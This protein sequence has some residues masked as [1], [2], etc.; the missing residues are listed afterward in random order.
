MAGSMSSKPGPF[1]RLSAVE[2]SSLASSSVPE[3]S[4]S[5]TTGRP[6]RASRF[7]GWMSLWVSTTGPGRS[8]VSTKSGDRE[9]RLDVRRRARRPTAVRSPPPARRAR[10][11]PVAS[12]PRSSTWVH[13]TSRAWMR[14]RISPISNANAAGTGASGTFSPSTHRCTSTSGSAEIGSGI[15]MPAANAACSNR[16]TSSASVGPAAVDEV[17][18]LHR[19][20][21]LVGV[22]PVHPVGALAV[23]PSHRPQRGAQV[24]EVHRTRLRGIRP[25][26]STS[27][28]CCRDRYR[29]RCRHPCR[30]PCRR[31]PDPPPRLPPEPVEQPGRCPDPGLRDAA[32]DPVQRVLRAAHDSR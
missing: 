24:I 9:K 6:S 32:Q 22:E 14:A 11:S 18:L 19:E 2:P 21:S 1:E 5:S 16:K 30:R 23:H 4:Q 15:G 20:R 25:R 7:H 29:G 10:A 3:I 8:Q 28:R 13:S 17:E 31:R 12:G 26:T 27:C